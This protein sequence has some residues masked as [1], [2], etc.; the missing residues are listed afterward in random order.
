MAA[1][2]W[3]A[4]ARSPQDGAHAPPPSSQPVEH[5]PS[6]RAI[7]NLIVLRP[8][9]ANETAGAY[10]AALTRSVGPSAIVL[11]RQKLTAVLH[12]SHRDAVLRGGY[13]LSEGGGAG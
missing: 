12:G 8:G 9:D 6:L 7:P 3:A 11:S 1:I 13:V 5:L 10:L 4:A 2:R